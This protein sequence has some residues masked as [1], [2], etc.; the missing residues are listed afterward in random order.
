MMGKNGRTQDK[1]TLPAATAYTYNPPERR[2]ELPGH[3]ESP[4]RIAAINQVLRQDGILERLRSIEA[5]PLDVE[6]IASVHDREYIRLVKRRAEEGGGY[7]DADT[8]IRPGTYE[9]AITAAGGVVNLTDAVLSGRV[10]NGFAL[11][12]PP[13]HHALPWQG[14]GFCIFNNVA[15]AARFARARHQ[16]DRI[17]IVDIDAHHGNGTQ[18]IFYSDPGVL[19]FSTHQYP[20]YPGTG[21]RNEI[22]EGPGKGY[23]VNIP[24]PYHVGDEGYRRAFDEVLVPV[25]ERYR[26]QLVLVS[27][28]YD[29]HW[30]EPIAQMLL[31]IRGY[32]ALVRHLIELANLWS[33]GRLVVMLEGGYHAQALGYGVLATLR[34]LE[35][36]Q[37]PISDPLGPAEW[38]EQPVDDLLRDVRK[39][40][41]LS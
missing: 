32:A 38:P 28:G 40:H 37:S 25:A 39:I 15:I 3:P 29:A 8:Y 23:T 24:F 1:G 6:Q 10:R 41:H 35:D 2:H 26:P 16:V 7:L 9:A 31:S 17:L 36:P 21:Q 33:R 27:I 5:T 30:A 34:L 22:G 20:F 12:R 13:G 11:I 14:M 18:E 4:Q 19:Y